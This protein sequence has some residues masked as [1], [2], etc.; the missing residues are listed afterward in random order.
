M[1]LPL[2]LAALIDETATVVFPLGWSDPDVGVAPNHAA[3]FAVV[4]AVVKFIV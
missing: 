2:T 4:V 1:F 3:E